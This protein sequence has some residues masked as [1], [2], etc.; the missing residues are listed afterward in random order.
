MTF[1]NVYIMRSLV[2]G[3]TLGF[4]SARLPGGFISCGNEVLH[5]D[6]ALTCSR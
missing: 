1:R 3:I 5:V 6:D 4:L 2:A